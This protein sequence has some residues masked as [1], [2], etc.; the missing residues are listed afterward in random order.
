MLSI[1]IPTYN[2]DCTLLLEQ[3]RKQL[4]KST[5]SIELIVCDDASTLVSN[6][7]A[8]SEYCSQHNLTYIENT[9]NLGRTATRNML[10]QKAQYDWLLF[11]DADV[12]LVSSTFIANYT[13]HINDTYQA[14]VG[15]IEYLKSQSD[16]TV[17]LRWKFGIKRE[18]RLAN[19][20]NKHPYLLASGNLL[21]KKDIFL[22]ANSFLTNEY[23]LDA[24]FGYQLKKLNI[25]IIHIDNPVYHL[26]LETNDV[27]LRKSI[28]ALSTLMNLEKQGLLPSDHTRLQRLY[29][30]SIGKSIF[31]WIINT[32]KLSIE[33]NLLGSRPSLF[34]FD[35]YRL[36]QYIKL[37][38]NA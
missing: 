34:L 6:K 28:N 16:K 24:V 25:P 7:K 27:F 11:L 9:T 3:L 2:Y 19:E 37:K 32:F 13:R 17:S 36:Y 26:G 14:I 30:A 20:R 29:Q 35:I 38:S 12:S 4:A 21:I 31:Q 5:H 15:G 22:Q 18:A 23:G 8:I 10:A 1:L 33:K